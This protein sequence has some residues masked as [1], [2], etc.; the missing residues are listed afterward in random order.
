MEMYKSRVILAIILAALAILFLG[1]T[2]IIRFNLSSI[3]RQLLDGIGATIS[4]IF[5]ALIIAM[6][7]TFIILI[8]QTPNRW[9][10]P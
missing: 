7:M 5:L 9:W 4:V 3:S 6:D 1:T 2:G 10:Q 8:A